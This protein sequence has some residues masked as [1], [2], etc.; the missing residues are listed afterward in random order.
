MVQEKTLHEKEKVIRLK[1][2]SQKHLTPS[3]VYLSYCL[4]KRG[5]IAP[6]NYPFVEVLVVLVA[7][8][9]GGIGA[10]GTTNE[11]NRGIGLGV[12]DEAGTYT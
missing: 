11:L 1:Q 8:A 5:H 7:S 9:A 10:G 12:T 2:T 6:V 3:V 4:L